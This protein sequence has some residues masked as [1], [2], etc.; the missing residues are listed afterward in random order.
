MAGRIGSGSVG[1]EPRA[2]VLKNPLLRLPAVGDNTAMS[3][4]QNCARKFWR[5]FSVFG[6]VVAS[7]IILICDPARA[8]IEIVLIATSIVT[9]P[10]SRIAPAIFA[11][12]AAE[13]KL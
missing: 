3:E 6:I 10:R 2:S 5:I 4:K 8:V 1:H 9:R 11:R 7:G 12:D 13:F